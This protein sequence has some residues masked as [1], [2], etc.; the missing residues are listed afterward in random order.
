[1]QVSFREKHITKRSQRRGMQ[2]RI[3]KKAS[4]T[5][6]V[7]ANRLFIDKLLRTETC[8]Q[9]Y[10]SAVHKAARMPPGAI[11]APTN[12]ELDQ[13][14]EHSKLKGG[15]V[16]LLHPAEIDQI[17]QNVSLGLYRW[18]MNLYCSRIDRT[19][20]MVSC[21]VNK[22]RKLDGLKPIHETAIWAIC[23]FLDEE[24]RKIQNVTIERDEE[25]WHILYLDLDINIVRK[26]QQT[27]H[28]R[29]FYV[30]NESH[31][32]G[33]RIG[34]ADEFN[35]QAVLA[36]YQALLIQRRPSP[37][38]TAGL[39]W[40][41]P[42]R[43]RSLI[44]PPKNIKT[45]LQ[46]TNIEF[47]IVQDTYEFPNW[48]NA[49][50]TIDLSKHA[51]LE[52]RFLRILDN[53]LDRF[54]GLGPALVEA[55]SNFLYSHSIGYNRDP[56]WQFPA[57]RLLFDFECTQVDAK[58]YISLGHLK[59]TDP[60]LTLWADQPVKIIVSPSD[61]SRIWVYD[62]NGSVICQAERF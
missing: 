61:R 37:D 6:A 60:L 13:L 39:V 1:M 14:I 4:E 7:V 49:D 52:D 26:N 25:K 57:L 16:F 44:E 21:L 53:Y 20:S 36:L 8:S 47:D 24:R 11:H 9:I 10:Y 48:L 32:F 28:P 17:F 62:E 2:R 31:V 27:Y 23:M 30:G 56:L 45:F 38:G 41:L 5:G 50:W 29:L 42:R 34:Q 3:A 19:V 51:I 40:T 46:A 54:H 59:Y 33:Y 22:N 55:K 58:G 43:I 35:E 18:I 12:L 15:E